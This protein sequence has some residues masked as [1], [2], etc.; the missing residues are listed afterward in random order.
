MLKIELEYQKVSENCVRAFLYESI[1]GD[2][3]F[4]R[5]VIEIFEAETPEKLSNYLR[6]VHKNDYKNW[7]LY[8]TNLQHSRSISIFT[9]ATRNM[10]S[11]E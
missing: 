4:G 5:S 2:S 11:E 9:L 1:I 3:D 7:Y 10:K 8:N 6:A